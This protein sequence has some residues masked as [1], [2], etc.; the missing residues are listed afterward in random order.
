MNKQD[1]PVNRIEAG[2]K[3]LSAFSEAWIIS[4][5]IGQTGKRKW[6]SSPSLGDGLT[7]QGKL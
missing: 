5:R 2:E 7:Y 3:T 6:A 1:L 4:S